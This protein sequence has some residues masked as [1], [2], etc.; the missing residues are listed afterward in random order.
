[1]E[2]LDT[3]GQKGKQS[4]S[5]EQSAT[6]MYRMRKVG[7]FCFVHGAHLCGFFVPHISRDYIPRQP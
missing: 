7:Q 1:M 2:K 5:L 6:D 3:D 4:K